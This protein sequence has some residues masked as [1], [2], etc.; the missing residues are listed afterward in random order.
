MNKIWGC[1]RVQVGRTN[2]FYGETGSRKGLG[3]T[4]TIP[5]H[6][7]TFTLSVQIIRLCSLGSWN[8]YVP[9]NFKIKASTEVSERSRKCL[10]YNTGSRFLKN[11]IISD[12]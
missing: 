4:M 7:L 10:D 12:K 6:V 1:F 5:K 9:D 11:D 8:L 2:T 3:E